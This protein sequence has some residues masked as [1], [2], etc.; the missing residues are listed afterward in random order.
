VSEQRKVVS[1]LFADVTGSTSLGE[2]LDPERLRALLGSYFG[3]MTQIISSWGGTV[4]KYIGDEIYA[5]FG[6][7][8]AHEDD[9]ARALRAADLHGLMMFK[10]RQR[11]GND[12]VAAVGAFEHGAEII[13]EAR[14]GARSDY[15]KAWARDLA[16]RRALDREEFCVYYQPIVALSDGGRPRPRID[17]DGARP[18]GT[19]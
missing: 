13:E 19:G 15:F 4:E 10:R 14:A 12:G 16:L 9:P 17:K 2:Q 1:I 7:P 8:V 6:A 18:L 5:L 11:L 3:E